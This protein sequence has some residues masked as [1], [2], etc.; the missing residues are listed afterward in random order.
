MQLWLL[1]HASAEAQA[2]SG[3]DEDRH[4]HHAGRRSCKA[5]NDWVEA[6]VPHRPGTVLVS[7]AQ[8]TQE[9]AQSALAGLGFPQPVTDAALWNAS[10]GDLAHLIDDNPGTEQDLMLI[11]HN[12][13]L[14]G[15][16]RWLGAR[17]P[18]TGMQPATLV[19]LELAQPLTPGSA[20]TL[21]CFQPSESI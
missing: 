20:S 1:R 5:L 14:E 11:G 7:P 13:G 19:I 10:P 9:T 17:L 15:V 6:N 2:T 16:A 8:R 12:P 4:L 18:I 3:R 21:A